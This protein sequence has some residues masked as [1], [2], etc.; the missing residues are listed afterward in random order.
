MAAKSEPKEFDRNRL[1]ALL[2][3]LIPAVLLCYG[4]TNGVS[5]PE[6]E[7]AECT[8]TSLDTT[9]TKC[10]VDCVYLGITITEY[11]DCSVRSH[12]INK[13]THEIMEEPPIFTWA[14]F[15]T[16]VGIAMLIG[17]GIMVPIAIVMD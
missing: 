12:V 3:F 2:Y 15:S 13:V 11:D 10:R 8:R 9:F 1:W 14:I 16:I 4:Y 17:G 6:F 7:R 5:Y